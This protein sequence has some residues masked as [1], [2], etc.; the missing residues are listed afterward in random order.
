MTDVPSSRLRSQDQILG[1]IGAIS[2]QLPTDLSAAFG[3]DQRRTTDPQPADLGDVKALIGRIK[4][5][6]GLAP[7][8]DRQRAIELSGLLDALANNESLSFT[9][10]ELAALDGLLHRAA[11]EVPTLDREPV[12]LPPLPDHQIAMWRTLLAFEKLDRPWVLVGGQM[13]MLHCLENN[14][15]VT[16]ATDDGDVIVGVWTRR[17]SLRA[18][19]RLLR[20]SGFVE[21]KTSDGYGYRFARHSP[22]AT[23]IDLLLP[24][25]LERQR[26]QPTTSLGRRGL[27]VEGGNQA[28]ARAQRVPVMV[29]SLSGYVRRPSLLGALVAKAHAYVSDSRDVDRHAED[30]VTLADIALRSP[31]ATLQEARSEDR[32]PIRRFLRNKTAEHRFFSDTSDPDAV[33][34]FLTRLAEPI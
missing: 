30:I 23:V 6:L 31:R 11:D 27:S 33:F 17:D 2:G 25:G 16:R 15:R 3:A 4:T 10:G 9:R 1:A 8:V 34:A 21:A 13:T 29:G 19:S 20:D 5:R 24:E 28:L 22:H 14:H 18:A 12:A 26:Q 7:A 32:K